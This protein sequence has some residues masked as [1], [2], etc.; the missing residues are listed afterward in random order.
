MARPFEI[1]GA[2]TTVTR[3]PQGRYKSARVG[4]NNATVEDPTAAD[5]CA[6]PES[7]AIVN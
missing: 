2:C 1:F 7:F 5:K 3:A 6:K 4:P